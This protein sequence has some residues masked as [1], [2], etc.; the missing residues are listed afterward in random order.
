L[1]DKQLDEMVEQTMVEHEIKTRVK[2]LEVKSHELASADPYHEPT[3]I[4]DS[5]TSKRS[6]GKTK[7]KRTRHTQKPMTA[8][9]VSVSTRAQD[10]S[11]PNLHVPHLRQHKTNQ[12]NA[13]KE[14][15]GAMQ[16]S[17]T[18]GIIT[19][20]RVFFSICALSLCALCAS[21][22]VACDCSRWWESTS[23]DMQMHSRVAA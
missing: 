18:T 21:V 7:A 9:T 16:T 12:E 10:F 3:E 6:K 14:E 17:V 11:T 22:C 8:D 13:K 20:P 15:H 2:E 4:T 5:I 19:P 23:E 1:S